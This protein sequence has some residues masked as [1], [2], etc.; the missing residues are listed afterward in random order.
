M[1]MGDGVYFR[2]NKNLQ[3]TRENALKKGESFGKLIK[4]WEKELQWNFSLGRII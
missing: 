4:N 1:R 3:I 2:T